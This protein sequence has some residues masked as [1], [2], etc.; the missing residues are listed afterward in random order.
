[1]TSSKVD[2]LSYRAVRAP[3]EHLK[4]HI[5]DKSSWGKC[6]WSL[7]TGYKIN[8]SINCEWDL[9]HRENFPHYLTIA[10]AFQEKLRDATL[11]PCSPLKGLRQW[12]STSWNKYESKT[13]IYR[14]EWLKVPIWWLPR[15][16]G[17]KSDL[18]CMMCSTLRLRLTVE[19]WLQAEL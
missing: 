10:A 11:I 3:L 13:K 2:G 19:P 9:L 12:Y 7:S 8:Q 15:L 5:R 17:A 4:D 14:H 16:S 6:M 18:V 1:M